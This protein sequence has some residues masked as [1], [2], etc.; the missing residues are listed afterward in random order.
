MGVHYNSL[1]GNQGYKFW[2]D[3]TK[4][5]PKQSKT[6]IDKISVTLPIPDEE[7]Q[8]ILNT[9]FDH[10]LKNEFCKP[11]AHSAHYK[12]GYHL[13]LSDEPDYGV[14]N[15]KS[16]LIQFN[17]RDATASYLRCEWNPSKVQTHIISGVINSFLQGGYP[18]L[19]SFGAFTRLDTA[20]DIHNVNV[21]NLICYYPKL[22]IS[23]LYR[24]QKGGEI[25]T[26]YLGD[27]T[28]VN[29]WAIY[30]KTKQWGKQ[31]N[32]T[33]D[34]ALCN[35]VPAPNYPVTRI[36]HRFRPKPATSLD[37]L[38]S[39]GKAFQNLQVCNT[40][41]FEALNKKKIFSGKQEE[42][43]F[44]CFLDSVRLR[45]EQSALQMLGEVEYTQRKFKKLLELG[46]A[47]W[48]N[49]ERVD[50]ELPALIKNLKNPKQI[51]LN[52]PLPR[53]TAL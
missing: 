44:R 5:P 20:I 46:K 45:G 10:Y 25:E 42:I 31:N 23:E 21:H 24:K 34:Y 8:S 41:N 48:Y 40:F 35:K 14:N 39:V 4:F 30:D 32:H 47:P 19:M 33:S 6:I 36:E 28:A 52:F 22:Q 53:F 15:Q 3:Q 7:D 27:G 16:L 11:A 18:R 37:N 13:C 26:I 2:G 51:P 9:A 17:P 50:T 29:Q 1:N 49:S 43:L 12:R 38:T